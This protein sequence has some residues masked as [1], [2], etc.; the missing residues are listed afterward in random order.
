MNESQTL[1]LKAWSTQPKVSLHLALRR[2]GKTTALARLAAETPRDVCVLAACCG[3]KAHA[4]FLKLVNDC[5]EYRH[6][7]RFDPNEA[8]DWTQPTLVILD[9]GAQLPDE[10]YD[11]LYKPALQSPNA[12]IVGMSTPLCYPTWFTAVFEN[13][14][15][16]DAAVKE[17]M[18]K[19]EARWKQKRI[20]WLNYQVQRGQDAQEA[21]LKIYHDERVA[22]AT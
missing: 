3:D 11:S 8:V 10:Y 9:D 5:G 7:T 12:R 4:N 2:A 19:N 13:K 6:I 15:V 14:D 22:K 17:E 21:L 18:A 20:E 1:W 16:T